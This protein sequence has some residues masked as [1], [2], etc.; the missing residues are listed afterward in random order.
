MNIFRKL[1]ASAAAAAIMITAGTA[2]FADFTYNYD[3]YWGVFIVTDEDTGESYYYSEDDGELYNYYIDENGYFRYY[4]DNT[5]GYMYIEDIEEPSE[6]TNNNDGIRV[7]NHTQEEIAKKYF[8]LGLNTEWKT[9]YSVTPS[10]TK[11]YSEGKLTDKSLQQS[12]NMLN[13]IRYTAGLPDNVTL[14]DD[15]TH[16]AQCAS[17]VN[18]ANGWLSHYPSKPSGMSDALYNDGYSGAQNS[19]IGMGYSSIPDSLVTG[20]MEDSD[21]S[22][23][24]CVGHRRWLLNPAMKKAGF[25]FAGRYTATYVIGE[26]SDF[27][28]SF[29]GDYI[30]WPPENMPMELYKYHYGYAFSVTVG[31]DYDKSSLYDAVV[32]VTSQK[33]GKSWTISKNS[34]GGTYFNVN[35]GGYGMEGCIIFDTGET[36][37][38]GDTVSVSISGIKK[39]S[40]ESAVISYNVNFFTICPSMSDCDISSVKAQ[41]YTGKAIKPKPTVKYNGKTLTEG[42]DYTLSYSSNKNIGTGII[43]VTGKGEYSGSTEIKFTIKPKKQ[44]ISKLTAGYRSFTVKWKKNSSADFYMIQYSTNSSMK[45]AETVY[46]YGTNSSQ[47]V[48]GLKSGKKYYVRVCNYVYDRSDPKGYVTG[49]WSAV[50]AVKV[51]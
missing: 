40:G 24:D 5:S 7:Q 32:K 2:A 47:T 16:C 29:A 41:V 28:K 9:E 23:I 49:A 33:T 42:V 44:T 19:N 20:Y 31:N 21:S 3:D 1:A 35:N 17:V 27:G 15:Y 45:K 50:K 37:E 34:G 39:N 8:D 43:T 26:N 4:N 22:N 46:A 14:D 38:S 25:G 51:K 10:I 30:A 6:D 13:F 11:P 18:A 36:F 48:S 12:L